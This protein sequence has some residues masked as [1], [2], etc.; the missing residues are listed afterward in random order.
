MPNVLAKANDGSGKKTLQRK[1]DLCFSMAKV[2]K[3]GMLDISLI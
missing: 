3:N 2:S 1:V